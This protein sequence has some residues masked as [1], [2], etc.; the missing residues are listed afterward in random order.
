MFFGLL[1]LFISRTGSFSVIYVNV[2]IKVLLKERISFITLQKLH[3]L[4]L[5]STILII[6]RQDK[7]KLHV[8]DS[9]SPLQSLV[10]NTPKERTYERC[11]LTSQPTFLG[12]IVYRIFL[13]MGFCSRAR[14]ELRY[15]LSNYLNLKFVASD[16]YS[17]TQIIT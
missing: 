5:T 1:F 2:D 16:G 4:P 14:E 9:P 15:K 7:R 6:F 3:W 10:S 11:T 17:T 13:G 8:L 12:Q